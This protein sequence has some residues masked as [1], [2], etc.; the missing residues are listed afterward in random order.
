MSARG[1]A[2]L[3]LIVALAG[4]AAAHKMAPAYLALEVAEGGRVAA[5]LKVPRI[6]GRYARLHVDFPAHCTDQTSTQREFMAQAAISRWTLSCGA[7][8]LSGAVVGFQ[9]LTAGL[10]EVVVSLTRPSGSWI[11][12]TTQDEAEIVL[13]AAPDDKGAGRSPSVPTYLRLGVVHILGGVDHLMFVAGLLLLVRRR[14]QS[15]DATSLGRSSTAV[16]L[17]TVTAFTV[18][19]SLTL[20]AAVLGRAS[21]P[22]GPVELTIALSILLLAVEL[23]RRP[24]S[25]DTLTLRRP[26][27]VAFGFGLLHGFGFAGAL[28]EIGFPRDH[29]AGALVL[30]NVGVELGQLLFIALMFSV[31]YAVRRLGTIRLIAWSERAAIYGLGTAATYWCCDRFA[32]LFS[33]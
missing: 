28:A 17:T 18:A 22:T 1:L 32:G 25:D 14:R 27:V 11:G 23:S 10:R 6:Q 19:H 15:F 30:F 7:Q 4:P 5:T 26:W 24:E 21:L 29:L 13:P 20:G 12:A 3:G 16:L 31:G 9:G 2:T 8:G 33:T